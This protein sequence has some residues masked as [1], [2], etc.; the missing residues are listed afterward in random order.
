MFR[1]LVRPSH[2]L[3]NFGKEG[4]IKFVSVASSDSAAFHEATKKVNEEMAKQLE[5]GKPI[6]LTDDV[7]RMF[8]LG[9]MPGMSKEEA[10]RM[11]EGALSGIA[12]TD[13]NKYY[14]IDPTRYGDW[15]KKGLCF[16]F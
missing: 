13:P 14:T 15:E 5:E 4:N 11:T 6:Q 7:T 12:D 8:N 9:P 1:R 2:Q 16:D 3:L 10:K